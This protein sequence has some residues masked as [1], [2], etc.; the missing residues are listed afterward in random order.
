MFC[1]YRRINRT[2]R[3]SYALLKIEDL[4]MTLGRSKYFSQLDLS[5]AYYQV[6]LTERAKKVSAF[7]SPFGLYEFERLNFGMVNA[8]M[9]FQRL[10]EQCFGD[11]NLVDLIIFLDDLLIHAKTL[12]ELGDKTIKVLDRLRHF[13]L[14]LDPDKCV[15]GA[16]E[17]RHLGF[18]I[19]GDGLRP[20]PSKI[21]ALTSWKVPTTVREVKSVIGFAGYYRRHVKNFSQIAKPLQDRTA[22]YIPR[23]T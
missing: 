20:D 1:D 9:T 19:S 22:E 3:D 13:N 16:K 8:P 2:V 18:L 6:P 23:G 17:V 11:M 15:F 10:M 21:E 5:K 7:T 14:K 4:F 12:E